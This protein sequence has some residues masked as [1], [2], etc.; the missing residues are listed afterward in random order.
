MRRIIFIYTR[1]HV[2]PIQALTITHTNKNSFMK[3]FLRKSGVFAIALL[4]AICFINTISFGQVTAI[5]NGNWSGAGTW[6]TTSRAGTIS[7][8]TANATVTGSA[9]AAFLSTVSPGTVLQR[10]TGATIGTVLSVQSNTSLTLTANASTTQTDVAWQTLGSP[11]SGDAVVIGGPGAGNNFS[12]TVDISN[13]ACA[14]LTM[15]RQ[16]GSNVGLVLYLLQPPE[17]LLLLCLEQLY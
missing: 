8:S 17:I 10:S 6:S 15:G 16:G 3:T 4:I 11:G 14:S 7:S 12:V 5:A 2:E 1:Y 9:T 13:A